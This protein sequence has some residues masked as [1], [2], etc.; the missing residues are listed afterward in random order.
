[1]QDDH[2]ELGRKGERLAESFLKKSGYKILDKNYYSPFGEIDIIAKER[3]TLV[4]V[5]VKTK[6]SGSFIPPEL[7]V[8][9]K[10]QQK[11]IKGALNYIKVLED[12][13]KKFETIRFDVIA[14]SLYRDSKNKEINLIR[15]AFQPE[16]RTHY[17]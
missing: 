17:I 2:L 6:H 5:E 11:I 13:G 7:S 15:D 10:K 12:K 1:M 9:R 14:I 8:N 16:G 4:F 3:D